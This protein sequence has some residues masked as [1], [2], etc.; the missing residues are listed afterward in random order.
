MQKVDKKNS[1]HLPPQWG[2]MYYTEKTNQDGSL[3]IKRARLVL[4]DSPPPPLERQVYSNACVA[5]P[6]H[7]EC[8][9]VE[10][11]EISETEIIVRKLKAVPYDIQ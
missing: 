8:D 5:L 3:T 6:P 11:E 1:I 9:F 2:G 4:D 7:W 10:T